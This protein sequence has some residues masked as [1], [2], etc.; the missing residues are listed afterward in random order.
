MKNNPRGH[1]E[2]NDDAT[3]SRRINVD[4]TSFLS[5]VPAGILQYIMMEVQV[6]FFTWG[7]GSGYAGILTPERRAADAES[8]KSMFALYC[9]VENLHLL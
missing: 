6:G 9:W 3:S 1:L 5:H 4:T 7:S 8:L 2:P